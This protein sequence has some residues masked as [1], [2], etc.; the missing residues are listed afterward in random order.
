MDYKQIA[1]PYFDKNPDLKAMYISDS[2]QAFYSIADASYFIARSKEQLHE[3]KN[4]PVKEVKEEIIEVPK[5]KKT[6]K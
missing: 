1:K 6:K 2:G 4:V 3:V 5:A